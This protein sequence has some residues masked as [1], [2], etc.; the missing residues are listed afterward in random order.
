MDTWTDLEDAAPPSGHGDPDLGDEVGQGGHLLALLVVNVEG[1]GLAVG[2][3][4]VQVIDIVTHA[5]IQ[6]SHLLLAD[7]DPDA[8][9]ALL[10][11]VYQLGPLHLLGC[12]HR[13]VQARV[14]GVARLQLHLQQPNNGISWSDVS[15]DVRVYI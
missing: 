8:A 14:H 2:R 1:L 7:V 4:L 6:M 15:K 13:G 11:P 10:P 12:G 5:G 9:E 3:H